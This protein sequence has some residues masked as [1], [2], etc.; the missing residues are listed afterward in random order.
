MIGFAKV[1][2]KLFQVVHGAR[3]DLFHKTI[4][5]YTTP[6]PVGKDRHDDFLELEYV[7]RVG[8]WHLNPTRR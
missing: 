7:I 1:C 3:S 8:G 4:G 6:V 2:E 5:R